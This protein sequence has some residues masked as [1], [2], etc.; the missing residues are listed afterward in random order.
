MTTDPSPYFRVHIFCC[1]NDRPE[2]HPKGSCAG[3]GSE[4]LRVYMKRQARHLGLDGVRVNAAGCLARCEL[5]PVVVIYPEGVWYGI[6]SQA[7][8]DEI[9]QVHLIGGGRVERLLL[10]GGPGPA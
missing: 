3:A 2:G 10:P 6:R 9:L 8:I 5:G 1:T 4:D 7:D